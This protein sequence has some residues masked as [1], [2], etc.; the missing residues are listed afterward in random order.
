MVK[1]EL[2]EA[3]AFQLRAIGHDVGAFDR[4]FRFAPPRKWLSDFAWPAQ[5]LL[6]EVDGG[7]WVYGRHNR[8]QGMEKDFEKHNAAVE[9][10]FRVL[11]YTG[12]QIDSGEALA[13]IER[14]LDSR[15]R[16]QCS[17]NESGSA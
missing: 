5:M 14:V 11:R 13:Q 7:G 17:Q 15:P 1:S 10:G 8:P 16:L 3:L 2:E 9:A 12:A 4:Q 6:V